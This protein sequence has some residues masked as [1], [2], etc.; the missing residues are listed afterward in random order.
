MKPRSGNINLSLLPSSTS[1]ASLK[2]NSN[3]SRDK[4]NIMVY[5]DDDDNKV[6][7]H[8]SQQSQ[9]LIKVFVVAVM[10]VA[11]AVFAIIVDDESST[12]DQE[13]Q[14]KQQQLQ[15]GYETSGGGS[16][17]QA[18]QQQ[19]GAGD[20][21][22]SDRPSEEQLQS[23]VDDLDAKVRHRKATP[24][25]IMETDPE[26]MKLTKELQQATHTLLLKRYG[27]HTKFRVRVDL[28]FPDV[29]TSKDGLPANDY[30]VIELAPIDLI[31]CS[32]YNFLEIARTWKKGSFHRNANH[33]LQVQSV[34]DVKRSMPFQE[35][36][37]EYPHA[38]GT[39][40]YAGRPSGPGWYVSILDNTRNHGPGSQQSKNPYEADSLFGRVVKGFEG[41]NSNPTNTVMRIHSTPQ[42]GWLT[43]ENQIEIPTMTI[44]ITNDNGVTW[45]PWTK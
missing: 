22:V 23:I 43:K 34:S 7:K 38:K 40:G 24:N 25:I 5:N 37:K 19:V 13:R 1:A 17:E 16:A 32:V 3:H 35:Y 14:W 44:Y 42:N 21:Y 4:D 6:A 10:L 39:T 20:V 41:Q 31:P 29:I 12:L 33:V 9:R 8:E 2:S 27:G 11:L 18:P 28:V 26:G 36:S 30:I 15:L 45:I